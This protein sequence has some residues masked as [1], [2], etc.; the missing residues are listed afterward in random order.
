M[1]ACCACIRR[2]GSEDY[3]FFFQTLQV[4]QRTQAAKRNRFSSSQHSH[5]CCCQL[6]MLCCGR[7]GQLLVA[8]SCGRAGIP[9]AH[10]GKEVAHMA[11]VFWPLWD[12]PGTRKDFG[13]E[14]LKDYP[15][16]PR[17]RPPA[18]PCPHQPTLVFCTCGCPACFFELH[19]RGYAC[20]R[21]LCAT[22]MA[23]WWLCMKGATVSCTCRSVA[24]QSLS[25]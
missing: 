2:L 3:R 11:A 25:S 8:G 17:A 21:L 7:Q 5:H 13:K 18:L 12:L 22:A 19:I 15:R 10:H 24:W 23:G 14:A 9:I 16:R 4:G 1:H 6:G 20:R